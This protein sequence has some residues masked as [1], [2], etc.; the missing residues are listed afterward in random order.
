MPL[1]TFAQCGHSGLQENGNVYYPTVGNQTVQVGSGAFVRFDVKNTATYHYETCGSGYDTQISGFN[2]GGGYVG[3]YNDDACGLQSSTD[4]T[5]TYSGEHRVQVNR[6]NCVGWGS[7]SATLTY[8][9]APPASP[10]QGT[11]GSGTWNV[12]CYAAGDAA[13]TGGAW[14]SNY[15]GFYT[16]PN[17]SFA[18][19][20]RWA[21]TPYDASG[22]LGCY[23]GHDNHSWRAIRTGLCGYYQIDING[24]D[25]AAQL[26]KNGVVIWQHMPGCCDAHPNAWTG[27]L[28]PADVLEFRVSEGGGGSNGQITLTPVAAPS[29]GDPATFGVNTWNA[30]AYLCNSTTLSNNTYMG[31]YVDNNLSFNTANVWVS[32][33]SGSPSTLNGGYTYSGAAVPVDYH[34]VVYKRQGFPCRNYQL[35]IPTHDDD[36]YVFVNGVQVFVHNGC[37][38]VHNNIWTGFLGANSTVEY[39]FHEGGGGSQGALNLV[40]LGALAITSSSATMNCG[41][42]ARALTANAAG[43]TWS[44]TGVSGSTFNPNTAGPGTHTI[45]YSLAGCNVTQNIT[46]NS[47]TFPGTYGANKWIMYAW[48]AGDALGGSGAWTNNYRGYYEINS[49]DWDTRTGQTYSTPQSWAN[50]PS[51]AL[52]YVGCTVPADNHSYAARRVG[53]PCSVYQI[54]IPYHDDR[55]ELRVDGVL[56]YSI[57]ACCQYRTN[58]WTGFLGATSQVELRVSEGGGGSNLAIHLIDVGDLAITSSNAAMSCS[59]AARALTA[60]YSGGTWSGPGVSGSNFSPVAAGLGTHTITYTH[61]GCAVTQTITVSAAGNPATFGSNQWNIYGYSDQSLSTNYSGYYTD[62]RL[63]VITTDRWGDLTS[64]SNATTGAN[65][66]GWVGCTVPVDNHSYRIKRQGFPCGLYNVQV[67]NDDNY[68]LYYNGTSI[69]TGVCCSNPTGVLSSRFLGPNSTLELTIVEGGANSLGGVTL[70]K[71]ADLAITSSNAGMTCSDGTRAL[72]ANVAGGTWSGTGV[73]GSTFNPTTAGTG[74]HTITYSLEGCTVTQNITVSIPGNPAT[75]GNNIWH[76]YGYNDQSLSTNYMGY[77]T[78]TRLS[79]TTTD[80]WDLGTQS[81]SNAVTGANGAGWTGC[82]VGADNHSYRIKRQ[83]FPCGFYDVQIQNDDNYVVYYN[84]TNIHSGPCCL[85]PT[86]VLSNR[87]LGPNSTLELTIVEGVGGSYGGFVL[88]KTADLTITSSNAAMC[89]NNGARALTANGAGGTWSGPGVSGSNFT[90]ASAGVGTHTITYSLEGCSATQTI[91][92]VAAPTANAGTTPVTICANGSI[93][94]L[95]GSGTNNAGYTWSTQGN[96]GNFGNV[97]T[98]TTSWTPTVTS[99]TYTLTLTATG[100]TP[101]ASA[102]ATKVVIIDAVTNGGSVGGSTTICLGANTGTL[103]LTGNTGAVQNWEKSNNGGSSWTNIVTTAS[104]YSEIPVSAGTWL[105]RAVVKNG[106][107][108]AAA[109]APSTITVNPVTVGGGV[110]GGTTICQGSST[111]TLTLSG[112]TGAVLNWEKSNNGGSSW[113]NIVH[114]GTT[115]SETANTAGTWLY[116]A[117]VKS[118]VC[119]TL[120]S[121]ATTV[122]VD[123]T[124]VPGSVSGGTTVCQN[125]STGTLT[126]SGHTG[127]VQFWEKSSNGGSSWANIVN[128]AT[129]YSETAATVGTWLYRAV[130]KNGTCTA[131]G[132][133]TTTVTVSTPTAGGNVSGGTTVCQNSSTGTLTLSGQT[134]GVLNWEKSNNAGSSWTNIVN[135]GTTYSETASTAGTWLYRAV[136]KNGA[137]STVASGTTTVTVSS[138]TV[139]GSVTGGTTICQG[140]ST[141]TLT[142]SGQ[143]GGVLNWE[144]SNNGG[145]SWTNIVHTG[146]TYSETASTAGTWLYRAVVKSGVCPTLPSAATTVTVDLTTVG[147]SVTSNATICNGGSTGT[148]TLGGN[149][150]AVQNWERSNNGGSSWANITNTGNTYSENP[151]SA[152]TWLYRAVVKSGT[153]A[154]VP[155]AAATITVVADPNIDTQPV[156]GSVCVGG[157]YTMTVAASGGTPSLTYKWQ[158]SNGGNWEDATP[159]SPTG[160]TYSG[161]ATTS[162]GIT[163]SGTTSATTYQY[164]V[165]VNATGNGCTQAIGSATLAVSAAL[166]V[167]SQPSSQSVC[168]G[169]NVNLNITVTGGTPS[170]NHQWQYDNAGNWQNVTAGSPAGSSYS[171]ATTSALTISGLNGGTGSA[172]Y[173]YRCVASASANGCGSVPSNAVTVGVHKYPDITNNSASLCQ[174]QTKTLT[175]DIDGT[176]GVTWTSAPCGACVSGNVFTAPNPGGASANYTLT[177]RNANNTSC[178]NFFVQTV[179]QGVTATTG[180]DQQQC[181]NNAFTVTGNTPSVGSGMWTFTSGSAAINS[182]TSPTT[183]I[184]LITASATLRWTVTNGNCSAFDEVV[185]TNSATSTPGTA[186]T[187]QTICTGSTPAA[188]SLTGS[189]GSIQWQYATDAAFTIGVSNI[190]GATTATLSSAQMGALTATRYYRAEVTSGSCATA[191]SNV[192]TVTVDQL[193]GTP[194]ITP[195][196]NPICQGTNLGLSVADLGGS[197]TYNWSGPNSYTASGASVTRNNI[198]EATGQGTYTVSVSNSCNTNVTANVSI[199]VH[200]PIPGVINVVY[201]SPYPGSA[202]TALCQG[203]D[204]QIRAEAGSAFPADI[205]WS[206]TGPNGYTANVQNPSITNVQP[207][208]HSGP[209][210]VNATNICSNIDGF[211]NSL[212]VD[213]RIDA[214]PDVPGISNS[215]VNDLDAITIEA[216]GA[217]S[218]T[219]TG[220]NPSPGSGN[221]SLGSAPTGTAVVTGWGGPTT[222]QTVTPTVNEHGAYNFVWTVTNGTCEDDSSIRVFFT[223]AIN[224]VTELAGC[225]FVSPDNDIIKITA[226]GGWNPGS[227]SAN[228]YLTVTPPVGDNLLVDVSTNPQLI[229]VYTAPFDGISHTY[230]VDDQI[231][232]YTPSVTTKTNHPTDIPLTVTPGTE[233]TICIDKSFDQW[234]TFRDNNNNAILSID[235]NN[236]DLGEVEVT[237]YKDPTV[238]SIAGTPNSTCDG[239][240]NTAMQRHFVITAENQFAN[241]VDVRLYFS[242]SELNDLITASQN[243]DSPGNNCTFNDNING[244]S[245]LYVTK[246]TG[247]NEDGDYTNNAPTGLY[248]VYGN[249]TALP[250]QPDGPLNKS[251][252]GFSTV[253][254]G[255]NSHHYVQMSVTEFSELWLHGSGNGAAL[256]VEMLYIEAN[257]INNAYINVRWATALEIN[258]NGFQVERSID[259][260]TWAAIGWVDGHNNTTTQQNYS[261]DDHTVQPNVRYY[262]R[263]KQIDNDG[264]YEYTGIVSAIINLNITFEVKDFIPNPATNQTT[265]LITTTN[266]QSIEVDI[267]N[268][269]GQKVISQR[270]TISKGANQLN[271]NVANLAAGTYTAVVSSA[272]EVYGKKLVVLK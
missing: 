25:D 28:T 189:V 266:D 43:G 85:N 261:Y 200:A 217:L 48:A 113:T 77:Y 256:P 226:N 184:T 160:V 258:N 132:S 272:N 59:D 26:L 138:T 66:N 269:I 24:H 134:G 117:V 14:S 202:I 174:G 142:L 225:S 130:V 268:G 38:D 92:V 215:G 241:P 82:A 47:P 179:Y 7:G 98:A 199:N 159:G 68:V 20:N 11:A 50:S 265:L 16:E 111:G 2:S 67:S 55:V 58:V 156:N 65:G 3:P 79:A 141:G 139:A 104:S 9:C 187:S 259:G 195:S 155:S 35:D 33:G 216:C 206:W 224:V 213:A 263:L 149:T 196:A 32:G 239:V 10:A 240:L 223:P 120:A 42:G 5:A 105:Y 45:T 97:N 169:S 188:I 185:L 172:S 57:D 140:A 49:I 253:Y 119:N 186:A 183:G 194:V 4:W 234:L 218:L 114:T 72:T 90:P 88:T 115:Y 251:A 80:R 233:T 81:P 178:S 34:T 207:G 13:G 201:Y 96:G 75:F 222:N 27:V 243:N 238:P 208:Q 83:G 41:D 91:T 112:Q 150:G 109:S 53:F 197:T 31:Y 15:S 182:P 129:T 173:L 12:Y 221:W 204:L 107:C 135:T 162:F 247:I 211:G 29:A 44:G 51:E 122:T 60:N 61:K 254:S 121:T 146:T 154:A 54:D 236:Q 228:S 168:E 229:Q 127:A 166:Q 270:H 171:G 118:G 246:Y 230:K 231:C 148:L 151:A 124:T 56:V 69:H 220:N 192:V 245:D 73:S 84:G 131:L 165:L 17:L 52:G 212:T 255:G 191:P 257:P 176:S 180:A 137:C 175:T 219:L 108:N 76:I 264:Q 249:P 214:N 30:Y 252:N 18:T 232:V 177:V 164:R 209:Y 193:V 157:A 37:C 260:Q 145:T 237:V 271:F 71:T 144:K 136:V 87:F 110:S 267:Y 170:V 74:T 21:N 8:R 153:C 101:C 128:T 19:T 22:Y 163:T 133:A 40:D 235:D 248:K 210:D 100:N 78:D 262:Y 89:I 86:P 205:T 125:T 36:V 116:R 181:N 203:S 147:G 103:T 126:L 242:E 244:I 123:A 198:Q 250:T 93:A 167:T 94:N 158:Y 99:G 63:S 46:V 227:Q 102:T 161:A 39:R 64:P 1:Q 143:I 95:G 23:I 62:T 106:V 152:G 6:F 190:S 70:T